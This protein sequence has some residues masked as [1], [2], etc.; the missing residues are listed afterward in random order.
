MERF[1]VVKKQ[2]TLW[3]P[4]VCFRK[5]FT[6]TCIP[7][8][9]ALKRQKKWHHIGQKQL[10]GS[11]SCKAQERPWSQNK[12]FEF[13]TSEVGSAPLQ[14]FFRWIFSSAMDPFADLAKMDAIVAAGVHVEEVLDSDAQLRRT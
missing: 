10:L 14:A 2:S 5:I 9:T 4:I 13:L 8:F 6:C 7:L 3:R 12:K 11:P 1:Q